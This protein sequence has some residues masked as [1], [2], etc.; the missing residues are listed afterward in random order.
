[1][2]TNQLTAH[3]PIY[4]SDTNL[5]ISTKAAFLG[6]TA[7]GLLSFAHDVYADRGHTSGALHNTTDDI[8]NSLLFLGFLFALSVAALRRPHENTRIA[9]LVLSLSFIAITLG[10]VIF[11][12]G[13][14]PKP[15]SISFS[16]GFAL[17]A[18]GYATCV[19]SCVDQDEGSSALVLKMAKI[20]DIVSHRKTS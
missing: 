7:I 20:N 14:M 8:V 18:V 1:M 13:N 11:V 10:T 2:F 15:V 4:D 17:L 16:V 6:A 5:T 12:W 9:D 3:L 19:D